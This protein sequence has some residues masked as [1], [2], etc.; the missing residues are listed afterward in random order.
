MDCS[1]LRLMDTHDNLL[2]I[3]NSE[4]GKTHLATAIGIEG[5]KRENSIYFI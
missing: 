3:G 2:F 1:I 5:S 4:V